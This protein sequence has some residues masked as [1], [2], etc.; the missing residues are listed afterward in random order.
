MEQEQNTNLGKLRCKTKL[1]ITQTWGNLILSLVFIA[2]SPISGI[3]LG[4]MWYQNNSAMQ[5]AIGDSVILPFLPLI[6][7]GVFFIIGALLAFNTWKNWTVEVSIFDNGLE[8]TDRTGKQQFLWKD[9]NSANMWSIRHYLYMIIPTGTSYI[10]HLYMTSGKI[11]IL[12]AKLANMKKLVGVLQE[13]LIAANV[14]IAP[15]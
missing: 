14:K 12:D 5:E 1:S 11:I 8:Y 13:R 10:V 7:A 6:V 2:L 15:Q 3:A 9:I 4:S